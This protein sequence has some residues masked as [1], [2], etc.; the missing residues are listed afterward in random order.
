MKKFLAIFTCA[1]NSKNHHGWKKLSHEEQSNLMQKGMLARQEWTKK[2]KDCVLYE[3]G[4]LGEITKVTDMQGIHDKPSTM[5]AFIVVLANSHGEAAEMFLNH[6]HFSIFPGDGV[7]I[8]ELL[9]S[10]RI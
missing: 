3:G 2:Y 6:P 4:S 8:T 7:E 1:E 5:G 9:D 10:S